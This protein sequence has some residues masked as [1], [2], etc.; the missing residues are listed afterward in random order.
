MHTLAAVPWIRLHQTT[1]FGDQATVRIRLPWP[2]PLRAPRLAQRSA[3]PAFRDLLVPQATA[4]LLHRPAPTL[5][6]YKFGR[7]ASRRIWMSN[8]WSATS[9]FS[10][11]FSFSNARS[12]LAT[13]GAIPPYF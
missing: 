10:W 9:F 2:I 6:V 1:Q 5:G 8:A 4:D 11:L 7:A 12:C 3:G 13:S